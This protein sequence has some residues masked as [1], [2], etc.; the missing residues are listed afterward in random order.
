MA[1]A[2]TYV[3][4]IV[5]PGLARKYSLASRQSANVFPS[6]PTTVSPGFR[7]AAAAGVSA[8]TSSRVSV[9]VVVPCTSRKTNRITTAATRFMKG[10]A[11][12][13][14]LRFQ[15]GAL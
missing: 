7:P 15:M 10:P 3:S 9:A 1:P 5:S 8:T 12:I 4:S 2:G 14:R 11:K 6:A 13:V